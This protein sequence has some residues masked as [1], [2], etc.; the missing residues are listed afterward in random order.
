M[1]ERCLNTTR[2]AGGRQRVAAPAGEFD[3][4]LH[5]GREI[6]F[7]VVRS[8]Q[9]LKTISV[10]VRAGRVIVRAPV[11]VT[12]TQIRRMVTKQSDWLLARLDAQPAAAPAAEGPA[13]PRFRSGDRLPVEGKDVVLRFVERLADGGSG[14]ALVDGE[15]HV[16]IAPGGKEQYD[17]DVVNALYRFYWRRSFD[18]AREYVTRY[19]PLAGRMPR[20]VIIRNQKRR[21]GS[22][23]HDGTVRLNWRLSM[24]PPAEAEYLIVHEL[25][26]LLELNHSPAF[27]AEVRR[28]LPG[29]G[30][31]PKRIQVD[32]ATLPF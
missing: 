10:A 25:C 23:A 7:E 11:F 32:M 4:V 26:H 29:R 24:L 17:V 15:L 2:Q 27:W 1:N 31:G 28:V 13:I 18:L 8:A 30:A 14:A 3:A 21:W 19:G 20:E 6:R 5:D 16:A 22:C 9:R 12:K